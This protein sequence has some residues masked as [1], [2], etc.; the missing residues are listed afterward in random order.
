MHLHRLPYLQHQR[1]VAALNQQEQDTVVFRDRGQFLER[2]NRLPIYLDDHIAGAQAA[3]RGHAAGFDG[4]RR[5][6]AA[7][8]AAAAAERIG[9]LL[10]AGQ[11]LR[12]FEE[13]R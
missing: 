9:H 4:V 5:T 2:L 6:D 8:T 7:E 10:V 11:F 1:T 12:R 13:V 3:L